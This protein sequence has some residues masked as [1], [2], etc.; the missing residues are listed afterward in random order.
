MKRVNIASTPTE[1]DPGDPPGFRA[2]MLRLG[3]QVDARTTGI[4]V[5]DLPPSYQPGAPHISKCRWQP[6]A[7]PVSPTLPMRSPVITWSP[8][9]TS[10]GCW[11]CM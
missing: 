2:A 4:S 10:A 11:R 8:R 9:A 5:Y 6:T 7:S 3:K 1:D